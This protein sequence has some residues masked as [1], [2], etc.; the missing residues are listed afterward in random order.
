MSKDRI[1]VGV[2][3]AIFVCLGI[4]CLVIGQVSLA[5]LQFV[6]A[7]FVLFG[8]SKAISRKGAEIATGKPFPTDPDKPH[9]VRRFSPLCAFP[10]ASVGVRR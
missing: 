7:G 8:V 3:T 5:I 6:L 2:G 4:Y 9:Q 1:V 10:C